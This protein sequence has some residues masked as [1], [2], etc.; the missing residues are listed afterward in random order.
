MSTYAYTSPFDL[1]TSSKPR[2]LTAVPYVCLY[3]SNQSYDWHRAAE[4]KCTI[5]SSD[6]PLDL[7]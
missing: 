5:V 1:S 6:T 4:A 3:I 2:V 7:C